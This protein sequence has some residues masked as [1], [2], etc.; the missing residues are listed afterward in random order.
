MCAPAGP[1]FKP[2]C[3]MTHLICY[4]LTSLCSVMLSLYAIRGE[5]TITSNS[6]DCRSN[7]THI[8]WKRFRGTAALAIPTTERWLRNEENSFYC[9]IESLEQSMHEAYRYLQSNL[10]AFDRPFSET[11][12]FHSGKNDTPGPDGLGYG[13]VNETITYALQCKILYS[14]TD[15]LP[16]EIWAEYVLNY[17][18][19]NEARSNWRPIL[20]DKLSPLLVSQG[21]ELSHVHSISEV[22]RLVNTHMWKILAVFSGRPVISFVAGSTPLIFDPMSVLVFG[23][24]SCTGLSI[25]FASALRSLGVPSRVAGTPAWFGHREEGNHN[26][27]EVWQDGVWY[28]V[29]PSP[30][31]SSPDDVDTIQRDPCT[32]WFCHSSRW[33]S[34]AYMTQAYAAR[35]EW[36]NEHSSTHFRLAWEW[37]NT[38]VPGENRTAYYMDNCAF[39]G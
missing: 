26:W 10:V 38:D 1:H 31:V 12:G 11:L 13:L 2:Y 30:A 4:R 16:F 28:F 35:S 27:V 36:S 37:H 21:D 33:N 5:S 22:V 7:T 34:T 20:F 14:F 39:C 6:I 23:Y 25:L 17:F 18:H 19:L 32:R 15:D 29:E 24:A 9:K 3:T 8:A